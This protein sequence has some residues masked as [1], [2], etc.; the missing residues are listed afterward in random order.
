MKNSLFILGDKIAN[1]FANGNTIQ[2]GSVIN[3]KS[4]T[5]IF[6]YLLIGLD[7]L[8]NWLM[9]FIY[10][11]IKFALNVID[12]LQYFIE[13]LVGIDVWKNT[14]ASLSDITNNDILFK[15]LLS[16]EVIRV[17][18][19]LVVIGIIL[20]IVFSIV[21][22]IKSEYY[23]ATGDEKNANKKNIL[24]NALKAIFM[25]VMVPLMTIFGILASNAILA[26]VLN[27]IRPDG[28]NLTLGGQIFVASAYNA[29]R[30]RLYADED[31]RR[32]AT[33]NYTFA[34][35]F[36]E[37]GDYDYYVPIDSNIVIVIRNDKYESSTNFGY[38]ETTPDA[39]GEVT[40][41]DVDFGS[42]VGGALGQL[43]MFISALTAWPSNVYNTINSKTRF[44]TFCS[45]FE[46][47]NP[48]DYNVGNMLNA[49]LFYNKGEEGKLIPT[50]YLAKFDVGETTGID[51]IAKFYYLN[52]VLEAN[53]I[54][55]N[56]GLFQAQGLSELST[57]LTGA[58]GETI[59]GIWKSLKV[60][61]MRQSA[62]Q[63]GILNDVISWFTGGS[64]KE[65]TEAQK[66]IIRNAQWHSS[67]IALNS[68]WS[69][70]PM[71]I[72][73]Y[74]TWSMANSYDGGLSMAST[75]EG[76]RVDKWQAQNGD[77]L[78]ATYYRNNSN[79]Q[80]Y[81][82]GKYG[83]APISSEYEAMGDF[84]DYMV[85]HGV[86]AYIVDS[87][88][89]LI[90]WSVV[91]QKCYKYNTETG[92]YELC[93][94]YK[95]DGYVL[96]KPTRGESEEQG[97]IFLMCY[98][99]SGT[100]LYEP[101]V[102]N[103]KTVVDGVQIV[104]FSSD[105]YGYSN[106]G[107]NSPEGLVIARG[108]FESVWG[109]AFHG[110]NK[111]N[112]TIIQKMVKDSSG[113]TISAS[114]PAYLNFASDG[115]STYYNVAIS[116]TNSG[117]TSVTS[118]ENTLTVS[119]VVGNSENGTI[120]LNYSNAKTDGTGLSDED[121]ANWYA[122][123]CLGLSSIDAITYSKIFSNGTY[124]ILRIGNVV[125]GTNFY[126]DLYIYSNKI[127]IIPYHIYN[128][129]KDGGTTA[130]YSG[131]SGNNLT[132]CVGTDG[133][134]FSY[135]KYDTAIVKMRKGTLGSAEFYYLKSTDSGASML[136]FESTTFVAGLYDAY[137]YKIDGNS[138]V[139]DFSRYD[140]S[141]GGTSSGD[142]TDKN[143]TASRLGSASISLPIDASGN[144]V[145]IYDSV[146]NM[147][148]GIKFVSGYGS[149]NGS[150]TFYY[151]GSAVLKIEYV[152]INYNNSNKI[153]TFAQL[154][155]LMTSNAVITKNAAG[156]LNRSY[157]TNY[158]IGNE[159]YSIVPIYDEDKVASVA[160]DIK[161]SNILFIRNTINTQFFT[162]DFSFLG[163]MRVK[164]G[165]FWLGTIS[166]SHEALTWQIDN[167]SFTLD[168]NFN[169]QTG[170][171]FEHLYRPANLNVIVLIA[172]I[173]LVFKVLMQ[174]AWG[175]VKRI[176]DITVLMMIMPGFCATFP[177]DN[178]DRFKKWTSKL[179]ST[180]FATYG[181]LIGL[182]IFFVLVPI[183]DS[184]TA[185]VFSYSA[186]DYPS[187]IR[188]SWI[189]RRPDYLNKL[190]G[191]MFTLVALTL[192]QTLPSFVSDL[193]G[194]GD[195]YGEGA[196]VKGD[197]D[198]VIGDVGN[199]VSGKN[200]ID[201][202][203]KWFGDKEKKQ[204]GMLSAFIPGSA[205]LRELKN[206]RDKD[207]HDWGE[208]TNFNPPG[209][210]ED[211]KRGKPGPSEGNVA[212]GAPG[213]GQGG[214]ASE[215]QHA[216]SSEMSN[217]A[218]NLRQ[219]E[220]RIVQEFNGENGDTDPL[221][222]M[223]TETSENAMAA[224]A[225]AFSEAEEDGDK[226]MATDAAR[227]LTAAYEENVMANMNNAMLNDGGEFTAREDMLE[228]VKKGLRDGYT[229]TA[230]NTGEKDATGQD[231]WAVAISKKNER[232]LGIE[233]T[234]GTDKE[235]E[236]RLMGDIKNY[237]KEIKNLD[238]QESA[239]EVQRRMAEA[240]G[241][242]IDNE[243]AKFLKSNEEV[244]QYKQI[245]NGKA[246]QQQYL[247]TSELELTDLKTKKLKA[248]EQQ[249][250]A[251]EDIKKWQTKLNLA[252]QHND[253]A[254]K[255]EAE[256]GL[257][258]A[259]QEKEGKVKMIAGFDEQ[260][261]QKEITVQTH[262]DQIAQSDLAMH[263]LVHGQNNTEIESIMARKEANDR[264]I[265][266][267][268]NM[269]K[270]IAQERAE[271]E[272]KKST[273]EKSLE[274]VRKDYSTVSSERDVER[275]NSYAERS[276]QAATEYEAA[277]KQQNHIS[278]L[279]KVMN[280]NIAAE[281]KA[282]AVDAYI[283]K[284]YAGASAK[285]KAELKA[286]LSTSEGVA[287]HAKT[288]ASTVSTKKAIA[289]GARIKA[290]SYLGQ[291][292]APPIMA[293]SQVNTGGGTSGGGSSTTTSGGSGSG[294]GRT[295]GTGGGR[296]G[297]SYSGG[298]SG[299]GSTSSGGSSGS[300]SGASSTYWSDR[301]N[302]TV[303][304]IGSRVKSGVVRKVTN[305][306]NAVKT[307][308]TR[309]KTAVVNKA[310]EVKDAVKNAPS[311]VAEGVKMAFTAKTQGD[312]LEK[313]YK[314]MQKAYKK[315][316]YAAFKKAQ[317]KMVK[318]AAKGTTMRD[319]AD[320]KYVDRVN[321][322]LG[323][324]Y[325]SV[326]EAKA[327]AE[328]AKTQTHTSVNPDGTQTDNT[329]NV[330]DK[331][332]EIEK[333]RNTAYTRSN[334]KET[335]RGTEVR[336]ETLNVTRAAAKQEQEKDLNTYTRQAENAGHNVVD[337]VIN[338]VYRSRHAAT[339]ADV[340]AATKSAKGTEGGRRATVKLKNSASSRAIRDLNL[341]SEGLKN[342]QATGTTSSSSSAG[343]TKPA[344]TTSS[345]STRTTTS[346]KEKPTTSSSST[347]A[348]KT[349]NSHSEVMKGIREDGTVKTETKTLS[350]EE[351]S[352]QWQQGIGVLSKKDQQDFDNQRS[353]LAIETKALER[354][355]RKANPS[356]G[357]IKRLEGL[358]AK[359]QA[360]IS[361][362]NK[363]IDSR[364]HPNG[365]N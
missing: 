46:A 107:S 111:N 98:Y 305:I 254:G 66:V 8:G 316:D 243:M 15:F 55:S 302:R 49:F 275:G 71:I 199:A 37:N 139:Y 93:V 213:D 104:A 23:N 301:E 40:A 83:F 257:N 211:P 95:E 86:T 343:T 100:G 169:S 173:V 282:K 56:L 123:K 273:A 227:K 7:W 57:L 365:T 138:D 360:V 329:Q 202:K 240:E 277:V 133:A 338:T 87:Q 234:L 22:I 290:N 120:S 263:K 31:E 101:V 161:P 354:E 12:L 261:R 110:S 284:Y 230:Y 114:T 357:E 191:L 356:A 351:V 50:Y 166:E 61:F 91:N 149:E 152:D 265:A 178:G 168:Y 247:A 44:Y 289:N 294:G 81:D 99:N 142:I 67:S 274:N 26:S 151:N 77:E 181:V 9:T 237:D 10:G 291:T 298:S 135:V 69:D 167:S 13:R 27:A 248:Q 267:L 287:K 276:K 209:G 187:T 229:A 307:A 246:N 221:A 132:D 203:H 52:E 334:T 171:G 235:V 96:Y 241:T 280:S 45:Q 165:L 297:G 311:R 355:R 176:Y 299:G 163:A 54:T 328:K 228:N 122:K 223:D 268:D 141:S 145:T 363:K 324:N 144:V 4:W 153:N 238:S 264:R 239:L 210:E 124:S 225:Q 146:G 186:A 17:F 73:A 25:A 342:R 108:V 29:N 82:G 58:G 295:G 347:T 28:N 177:I 5:I 119:D 196:K 244:E 286:S 84:I 352:K 218:S 64:V 74:N 88:S 106:T 20:L 143:R 217:S 102:P 348:P 207:K 303:K 109:S 76:T 3:Q 292:E 80:L 136:K 358:I 160:N 14:S 121:F 128:I 258:R 346:E 293:H 89:P 172:S 226:A 341:D 162:G 325:T 251:E 350:P 150:A 319:N 188:N 197:V 175:L 158:I 340:G 318:I 59:E 285:Q 6:D 148:Y 112:P 269:K 364:M 68:C 16:E 313:Q 252:I 75:V 60:D 129:Y 256:K 35:N 308:P 183:I 278:G 147:L 24:V 154:K 232:E 332:N 194:A 118:L 326:A 42:F 195:V 219:D 272:G 164:V 19:A 288:I 361:G 174:S 115:T 320:K 337:K 262:K 353:R 336:E 116:K 281:N 214:N 345:S 266:E 312:K 245:A 70:N 38:F 335:K 205:L 34:Y 125:S 233:N 349:E 270:T 117:P 2:D 310:H 18:R 182:N 157:I 79:W 48:S 362:Y 90:D 193:I 131:V 212:Y 260:I 65:L 322:T 113:K 242:N 224:Y 155:T 315:G 134:G 170:I 85:R 201:A 11:I 344:T 304:G 216:F 249:A 30:Y 127:N 231:I 21:A 156:A 32:V 126:T 271:T 189:I 1:L 215:A 339:T 103:K 51:K 33:Y 36:Y 204:P 296:S 97:A 359:R 317:H 185:N 206:K 62:K 192:I 259:L 300:G 330:I 92:L 314:K 180:I 159:T 63:L 250:E 283:N 200:L 78:I 253:T 140:T 105:A 94:N 333:A 331:L 309:I 43:T 47:I 236:N 130:I 255:E 198:K 306:K 220:E 53:V 184:A 222:Q 137:A 327:A 72:A 39:N 190:V 208:N 321:A 323:T 179:V 279:S 41:P